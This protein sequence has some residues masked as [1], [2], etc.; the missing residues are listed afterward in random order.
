L[1]I[2]RTRIERRW[3]HHDDSDSHAIHLKF[4]ASEK[5]AQEIL[6]M[7]NEKVSTLTRGA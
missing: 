6:N 7:V 5:E 4:Y 1:K 3:I 2:I